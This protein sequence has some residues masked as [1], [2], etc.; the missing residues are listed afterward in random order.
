[1]LALLGLMGCGAIIGAVI[2]AAVA[3]LCTAVSVGVGVS[4]SNEAKDLS[5]EQAQKRKDFEE[6]QLRLQQADKTRQAILQRQN[7]RKTR[8]QVMSSVALQE[9]SADRAQRTATKLHRENLLG[10][11]SR[12]EH[13]TAIPRASHFKGNPV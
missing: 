10:G 8:G 1:M 11:A 9:I 7:L 5:I 12:T 2:S 3:V 6:K 13:Q 4:K